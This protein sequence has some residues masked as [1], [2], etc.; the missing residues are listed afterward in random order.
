MIIVFLSKVDGG[1]LIDVW[2]CL[3][4]SR[5]LFGLFFIYYSI[6][7][8]FSRDRFWASFFMSYA[9]DGYSFF[10]FSFDLL[11]FR[12]FYFFFDHADHLENAFLFSSLALEWRSVSSLAR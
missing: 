12:F 7:L 10:F 5:F 4:E 2:K 6:I 3:L 9:L 11:S 8:S 1:D